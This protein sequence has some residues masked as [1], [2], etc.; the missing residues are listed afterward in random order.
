MQKLHPA[1][2]LVEFLPS[3]Y[4]IEMSNKLIETDKAPISDKPLSQ[5]LLVD[6]GQWLI[7]S[8]QLGI[9]P[10]TKVLLDGIEAQTKQIME[11][12]SNVLTAGGAS[13]DDVVKTTIF[14]TNLADGNAVNEIYASYFNG[15]FPTR[16]LLEV[17]ALAGAALI[18]I[19]TWAVI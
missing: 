13:F 16:S 19:E 3:Y 18:E 7:C 8:G 1:I 12:I 2:L 10:E 15:P 6:S 5:A 4:E 14:V 9:D 11:N 17:S